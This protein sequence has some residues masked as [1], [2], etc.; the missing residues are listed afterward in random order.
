MLST[1]FR[2]WPISN[3]ISVSE[4]TRIMTLRLRTST[5]SNKS[6]TRLKI[7]F[8]ETAHKYF[9]SSK[10]DNV[11]STFF[12]DDLY[13]IF[14]L[15]QNLLGLWHSHLGPQPI[16]TSPWQEWKSLFMKLQNCTRVFFELEIW[17][18]VTYFFR[19]WPIY[20]I[21]SLF[22]SLLG[23]W[24]FYLGPH[25]IWTSP[26]QDWKSLFMKLHKSIFWARILTTC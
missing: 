14:S 12:V 25:P 19:R 11:L 26:W 17:Q 10:S 22:Q 1:F 2:R 13:Q 16:R 3:N 6:L 7:T 18:R 9:L 4:N 21:L 8:H 15:F 23:L 5:H 24:H 20:E